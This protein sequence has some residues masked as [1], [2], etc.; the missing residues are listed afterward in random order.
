VDNANGVLG[1]DSSAT[2]QGVGIQ[3]RHNDPAHEYGTDPIEFHQDGHEKVYWSRYPGPW[4]TNVSGS[5]ASTGAGVTHK[6]PLRASIYRTNPA[7]D[8]IVPG[9]VRASL[10]FVIKYP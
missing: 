2:A 4:A 6:I 9:L 7:S 8:P 5:S 10:I 1:L 3:I